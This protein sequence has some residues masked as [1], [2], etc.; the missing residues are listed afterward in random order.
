MAEIPY[1]TNG[2]TP[3]DLLN[4]GITWVR[5]S[6][7]KLDLI[8]VDH[9]KQQADLKAMVKNNEIT[10]DAISSDVDDLSDDVASMGSDIENISTAVAE[11]TQKFNSHESTD[12]L[13]WVTT[14]ETIADLRAELKDYAQKV[15]EGSTPLY[16]YS[17]KIVVISA[18]GLVNLADQGAYTVPVNGAIQGS[19]GGLLGVALTVNVNGTSVWVSPLN[20]LLPNV[21]PEIRVN[22][23]DIVTAVGVL[24]IGQTIN[25]SFFPNKG[26][27]PQNRGVVTNG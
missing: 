3:P 7:D 9:V 27:L 19:V 6:R 25:V 18:G 23:G 20:L 2:G 21:S 5:D 4:A 8:P 13:R 10:I 24:G 22:A 26:V 12:D 17:Q 14:N 11:G 16:D 1:K 15:Y